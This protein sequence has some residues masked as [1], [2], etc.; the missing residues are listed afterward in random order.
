MEQKNSRIGDRV[1]EE[2]MRRSENRTETEE[3][4]REERDRERAKRRREDED[5]GGQ[6]IRNSKN[7]EHQA[8]EGK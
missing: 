7:N 6:R 1:G 4:E 5:K 8:R 3:G 2:L